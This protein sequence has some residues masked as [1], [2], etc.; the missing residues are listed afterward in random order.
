MV[1]ERTGA[2]TGS[3]RA[4]SERR[5]G[6]RA[7]AKLN[8]SLRVLAREESGY[9]QIETTFCALE[10]A[11]EV[12]VWVS[13]GDDAISL[14]VV[15]GDDEAALAA[16]Y[17]A[18]PL[19]ELGPAETN[20]AWRAAVLYGEAT[21]TGGARISVTKRI[22]HGAGLGGGSSDAA[23]VLLAL[24]ELHGSPLDHGTLLRLGARLGSD[25]AFF[26]SGTS[27]ALGWGRGGRLLPLPP[28]PAAPVVLA[29]PRVSVAT[30]DAY[31][32][33]AATR[34]GI[35]GADPA[36]AAPPAL[37][38]VP[39]NWHEAAET[40]VNDFEDV[41]FARLPELAALREALAATGAVLARMTGTG[42]V[43]FG[44]YDDGYGAAE[45]RRL[46]ARDFTGV[47]TLMT[48]TLD[49]RTR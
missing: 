34:A 19:T 3:L 10:L 30:R 20:L 12:E 13:D 4:M 36:A 43:V 41:V 45:A 31:A 37:L 29:I 27:L 40:A 15:G 16:G 26:L 48:S 1:T 38:S 42:S 32:T 46:L 5:A 22:P 2:T 8:L 49:A 28:L 47:A 44:I 9:H 17:V 14:D 11:D 6:R 33:L 23:A 21:G 7:P 35:T 39:T 24:N 25:V 18:G